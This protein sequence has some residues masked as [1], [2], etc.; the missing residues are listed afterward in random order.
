VKSLALLAV[1]VAA[2]LAIC[3]GGS[4]AVAREPGPAPR[5]EPWREM[6]LWDGNE[7]ASYGFAG[8][9]ATISFS[10]RDERLQVLEVRASDGSPKRF[11]IDDVE[12]DAE[13]FE[14][15]ALIGF[16]DLDREAAPGQVLL[17]TYSCHQACSFT[18]R[19]AE[20]RQ[21]V[22]RLVEI[23][24]ALRGGGLEFPADRDGDGALELSMRDDRL[25][26]AYGL[27]DADAPRRF[28]T[29]QAGR[30]VDVTTRPGFRP[31]FAALAERM[32]PA[33]LKGV[34]ANCAAFVAASARAGGFEPAWRTMLATTPPLPEQ[35]W[36]VCRID[37]EVT[38]VCPRW[39]EVWVMTFPEA[40]RW[41]LG[42][43]G[44]LP[45]GPPPRSWRTRN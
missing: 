37:I 42:Q 38:Q 34:E 30:V 27:S 26:E 25:G 40:L 19:L 43:L 1:C 35:R 29:V 21:G 16:A 10:K 31:I 13:S 12:N 9:T 4:S 18:L 17:A 45:P 33:C 44:Y 22:W 20:Q 41:R 6:V 24:T 5:P 36:N 32:R 23:A 2:T 39:Q 14:S 8:V 28:L 15:Q 11:V 7:P 3:A